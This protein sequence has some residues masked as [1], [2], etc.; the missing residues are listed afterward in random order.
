MYAGTNHPHAF[1]RLFST[2]NYFNLLTGRRKR[3]TLKSGGKK[4]E[5]A[6][7]EDM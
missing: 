6:E 4:D 1:V 2:V 5:A 3:K 7:D